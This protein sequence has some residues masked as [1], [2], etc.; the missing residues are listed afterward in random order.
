MDPVVG[1]KTT[2][3]KIG[4]MTRYP[5]RQQLQTKTRKRYASWEAATVNRIVA[6]TVSSKVI[7]VSIANLYPVLLKSI[8]QKN[9]EQPFPMAPIAPI[10]VKNPSSWISSFT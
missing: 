10:K 3:L 2:W 5:P 1:P 7:F 6:R 9:L 4:V 8:L